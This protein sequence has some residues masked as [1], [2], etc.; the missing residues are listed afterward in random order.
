M[1]V[2]F[3]TCCMVG[4]IQ[5]VLYGGYYSA[6]V[7]WGVLFSTCCMGVLFGSFKEMTVVC[8]DELLRL[9]VEQQSNLLTKPDL[10]TERVRD[11]ERALT[12]AR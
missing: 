12:V 5:H 3:S 6:R 11:S 9:S 4:T 10:L 7:V 2:L 8:S 1:G